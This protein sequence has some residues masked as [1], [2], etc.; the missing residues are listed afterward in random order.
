MR[1]TKG[2]AEKGLGREGIVE[3]A[4]AMARGAVG[5]VGVVAIP[6]DGEAGVEEEI[7]GM[8]VRAAGVIRRVAGSEETMGL[9][10]ELVLEI[11]KRAGGGGGGVEKAREGVA[12]VVEEK[13]RGRREVD[14][15][16][17]ERRAVGEGRGRKERGEMER[18]GGDGDGEDEERD[19]VDDDG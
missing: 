1:V 7:G 11:G 13:E 16:E 5:E 18:V 2:N 17:R 14:G 10:K 4:N 3:S 15:M 19:G 8:G 12:N 6:S 9:R